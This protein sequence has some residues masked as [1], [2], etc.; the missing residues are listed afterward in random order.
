MRAVAEHLAGEWD[1]PRDATAVAAHFANPALAL[2]SS[3]AAQ[4]LPRLGEACGGAI[5]GAEVLVRPVEQNERLPWH[6]VSRG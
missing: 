4:G 3:A 2:Q 6:G 5:L 1:E